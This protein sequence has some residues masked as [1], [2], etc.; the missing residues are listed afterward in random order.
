MASSQA[1]LSATEKSKRR[2]LLFLAI[3][4]AILLVA[5]IDRYGVN[6]PVG[7]EWQMIPLFAKWHANQVT[8]QDL[9]R[10]H[11]E[12]RI[13][14]PKLIFIAFAQL[15]HWNLRAEM[16]FSVALVA[17]ASA[18]IYL[19]IRRTLPNSPRQVALL[20]GLTNLLLFSTSQSENWLW[21]FQLQMFIP[22]LCLI[23]ALV[24]ITSGWNDYTKI[25]LASLLALVATFSFGNGLLL[26]PIVAFCLVM[27]REKKM[28]VLIWL[29]VFAAVCA[30]YFAGY[31]RH[32]LPHGASGKWVEYVYYFTAFLGGGLARQRDG[33]LVIVPI[34]IGTAALLLYAT[35]FVRFLQRRGEELTK[36]VPWL[37]LGAY[38]LASAGIAAVARIDSGVGQAVDSRYVTISSLLYLSLVMLSMIAGKRNQGREIE[39]TR[40]MDHLAAPI[41]TCVVVLSLIA[42]LAGLRQ[43]GASQRECVA[44]LGALQ[45]SKVIDA[46][47]ALHR[48]LFDSRTPISV[49]ECIQILDQ[50]QLLQYPLRQTPRIDDKAD[51]LPEKAQAFGKTDNFQ[52]R[53][54]Q[55]YEVSG[56][57]FLPDDG[58]PGPCVVLAY[59]LG[60]KWIGFA[61]SDTRRS[62]NDIAI[63]K[64]DARYGESGWQKKFRRDALPAEADQISAWAIDPLANELHK[65]PGICPLPKS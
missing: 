53:D 25:V 40:W 36:A 4:P 17:V 5:A 50:L 14:F 16:F 63:L 65:L 58:V 52:Q 59:H 62:R 23:A 1:P 39:S 27:R 54:E 42:M 9:Y 31:Q 49:P 15:T 43:M 26:W 12:H 44:G 22:N 38:P 55:T 60:D 3:V 32:A 61:L 28:P 29:A 33:L 7:D 46:T 37:A 51:L 6:V 48:Y 2:A 10:Q 20:W 11:N 56:W 24:V 18:G 13:F 8:F 47:S 57:A 30:C 45:F 19:L 64:H 21:G 41:T 35:L 34:L